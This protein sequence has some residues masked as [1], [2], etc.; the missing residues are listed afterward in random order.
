MEFRVLGPIE[1]WSAG[2]PQEL[3]PARERFVLAILLLTPRT[4][5]PAET[6]IDRLWDTRPPAKARENL[7]AYLARLRASLR[8]A[9]GGDVQVAGR[10]HGYLLDVDPE[11]VDLHQF[12]RLR[13]RADKL[14]AGGDYDQAATLLREADGLWRGPA[15][16]GIDG[17][18]VSRM[19]GSLDEER[20][21]A[22]LER[23][24][25]ELALG[26]HADLVGELHHL[27]AQ[28]PLDETF[29]AHHMTALYRC[30]RPGDALSLY[31][32][33]RSRLVEEQGTEPGPVLSELHQRILR[34]DP[35]LAGRAARPA[36]AQAAR[37]PPA[38]AARPDTLPPETAEFV[39]R[40]EELSLLVGEPG[41]ASRVSVIVGMPGVGK[42]ALAVRAARM[43]SGQ[44]PDGVF[45]LNLHSHD[46][47]SPSL[48]AGEA[49]RLLLQM[50][51]VPATQIPE[52]PGERAALWRAQLSRR[53]AVVILDDATGLDQ[54]GPLLPAG[55]RSLILITS[56]YRMPGLADARALTLDV[57]P[58]DDAIA[59]FQRIAGGGRAHDGAEVAEVVELCGRLP[60]AIRLTAGRLARD[61]PQEL[62]DLVVELSR[63]PARVAGA[64]VAVLDWVPAFE[65][66]Y[67]A[68]SAGHQEFFRRLGLSPATQIS[69]H[70]AA[71]LGGV[72]LVEAREAAGALLDHHL[73]SPAPSGQFVFHD[74][75][76]G[77]A[78]MCAER[79]DP[80]PV[81]R[82]AAGRL[83]DYYLHTADRADRALYPFRR[84]MPVCI[85]RA[86]ATVP[87]LATQEEAAA[88]LEAEWR[89]VLQAAQYAARHE[90]K[91]KCADLIHALAGFVQ[92]RAH[93]DEAIA[94]HTLALQASRDIADPGRIAQAALELSE[95]SQE[96]GRHEAMLPLVEDAAAIYRSEAD[97][98]G[99][100]HALDQIG[101]AHLRTGRCREALAYFQEARIGYLAVADRHGV[102]DALSH[103]AI[104]CWQLGRH[105][106]ATGN[107][108]EA[109]ALYRAAG[110]RRGEAKTLNNLGRMQ[111]LSGYHRDALDAYQSSLRIF[112]EIGGAQNEA[113]L[114]HNIGGVYDYKGSYEEGLAA[115]QRALAI[116]R[117]IGDLPNEADVL[118]DIGAIY[119]KAECYDDA[120]L[121]HERARLIAEEIGNASQQVIALR[122]IADVSR[123][124]GRYAE[125][126]DQYHAVLKLAVQIGDPYEE[127]KILEGIAETTLST[128]RPD[129]ARI[130]FR[131]ALDIFERL[132]VPEAESARIR[133]ETM[134]P[135]VGRLTP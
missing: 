115:Y 60:L 95:V 75:I 43:L 67:R 72:T 120:L 125:A 129:A 116:Y 34:R 127:A 88:W 61:Y 131:Q 62:G 32:E 83:L 76:R 56:R 36:T 28:Y 50:L 87:A 14:A 41:D 110:D 101:L 27:L 9:V 12:R 69:L 42:T 45:Y 44:Y 23:V 134:D 85:T 80:P 21:A 133:M 74:L 15:L 77:Y 79:D 122:G 7:S 64:D 20:R 10:A 78:A 119:R 25:C 8:Q 98:R 128:R 47:A 81:R 4:I 30:G 53:R 135:A 57:L 5:V 48:D 118:N 96:T 90:W 37:P 38:R 104:S 18:W 29:I 13:R 107:L 114:Y 117:D 89:N 35:E 121:H 93:W 109:L 70:A 33:T 58:V 86:P 55:G 73:L 54:V 103:S 52:S 132:G 2:R 82:R 3:G 19:R 130:L 97:R 113:I 91:R 16:A 49:L 65:L 1:L 17:D 106:D 59:L 84:R 68:L 102:A 22:I 126:L 24:E 100:A 66:S 123:S 99:E 51:T 46:P 39:G 111:L 6:L 63:P 94:A 112:A 40:D 124:S 92:I 11:A 26:R 105:Q 71:A 31:R 108:R